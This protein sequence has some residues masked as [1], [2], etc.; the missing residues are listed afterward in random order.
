MSPQLHRN[1][2]ALAAC[3]AACRGGSDPK[4]LE[5]LF[6]KTRAPSLAGPLAA[7][8]WT[9]DYL[10]AQ[11]AVRKHAAGAL[12]YRAK[13]G[14]RDL[15][16]EIDVTSTDPDNPRPMLE[17]AWGSPAYLVSGNPEW[18]GDHVR[19][20]VVS[21]GRGWEV[22]LRRYRP[23]A[24]WLGDGPTFGFERGRSLI[25]MTRDEVATTYKDVKQP[26]PP[27][28][29][30][31]LELDHD[32][33]EPIFIHL[34]YDDHNSVKELQFYV[35]MNETLARSRQAVVLRRFGLAD[36]PTAAFPWS[37]AFVRLGMYEAPTNAWS[38]DVTAKP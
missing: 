11:Q 34:Q 12:D 5:E 37:G 38:I 6:G 30:D 25:G 22:L 19:A 1:L 28:G 3:A 26:A 4:S 16:V 31:V 29:T 13:G 21:Y 33:L 10:P 14:A 20:G 36:R 23:L 2:L 9:Q 24:E 8:S 32:E 15:L 18:L 17:Q 7:L 27:P 35:P